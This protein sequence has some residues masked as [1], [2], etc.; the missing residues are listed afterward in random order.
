[1][2]PL[3]SDCP[4][5]TP[6]AMDITYKFDNAEAGGGLT[7]DRPE[8]MQAAHA[9]ASLWTSFARNGK[10]GTAE[11]PEWPAYDLT[12]RSVEKRTLVVG[13]HAYGGGRDGLGYFDSSAG[14]GSAYA[15]VGFRSLV[16]V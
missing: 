7:G 6:H 16:R 2:W 5:S 1:M 12:Q 10:P 14:V 9:F 15:N 11:L 8:R 4:R 3:F 13:G